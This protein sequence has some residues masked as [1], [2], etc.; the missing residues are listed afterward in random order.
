MASE[1]LTNMWRERICANILH[2]RFDD[3]GAALC[4]DAAALAL[5]VYE[6]VFSGLAKKMAEVPEGWLPTTSCC[7]VSFAGSVDQLHFNGHVNYGLSSPGQLLPSPT[8]RIP[9]S[10]VR[11]VW[12]VYA[13]E[14]AIYQEHARI[15][16]EVETLR[17]RVQEAQGIAMGV[18]NSCSTTGRLLQKWPE[19]EPFIR[20]GVPKSPS[21]VPMLPIAQLN[22]MLG[23]PV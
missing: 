17:R 8:R 23:L 11:T 13:P 14:T 20:V 1:K 12:A 19:A 18:L 3:E 15:E 6:D 9:S 10:M 22:G 2:R 4:R 5:R 7:L 16:N 21:T